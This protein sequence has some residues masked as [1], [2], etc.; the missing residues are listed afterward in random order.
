MK[1]SRVLALVN[2][3]L[4]VNKSLFLIDLKIS[5][6]AKIKV[7]IDGDKGVPLKECIRISRHIEHNLDRDVDDFSLEVMSAGLSEPLSL[8]RQYKK[9][10]NRVL[11]I[12][13]IDGSIIEGSL[14]IV[15]DEGLSVSWKTREPKPLGKGKVTVTKNAQIAF[16]DIKEAKV[17]IKFN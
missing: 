7:I 8:R 13:L 17:K 6:D 14:D 1:Q 5:T 16:E 2:E 11:I 10:I 4:K 3:A 9:N 12:K 15:N